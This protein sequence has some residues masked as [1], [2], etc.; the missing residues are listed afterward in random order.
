M[1]D[2]ILR[3][4]LSD[5]QSGITIEYILLSYF[6]NLKGIQMV[7]KI[8]KYKCNSFYRR[9]MDIE[10]LY[11]HLFICSARIILLPNFLGQEILF[12][13]PSQIC[14]QKKIN[15]NLIH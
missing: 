12:R 9:V 13:K 7:I 10:K 15:L 1:S 6:F 2:I 4:F 14:Q 5:W 8:C 11:S 3:H